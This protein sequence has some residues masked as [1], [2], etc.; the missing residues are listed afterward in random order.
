MK[1]E[2]L[3][4]HHEIMPW[5]EY[6]KLYAKTHGAYSVHDAINVLADFRGEDELV[7]FFLWARKID[8]LRRVADRLQSVLS[9]KKPD[10]VQLTMDVTG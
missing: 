1:A 3:A 2:T 4:I 10:N 7:A 8:D 5:F 6:I 9:E